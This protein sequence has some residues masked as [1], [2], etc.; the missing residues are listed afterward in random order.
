ML[1]PNAS[2]ARLFSRR[3]TLRVEVFLQ[4]NIVYSQTG[5][6]AMAYGKALK[7]GKEG[8]NSTR[9]SVMIFKYPVSRLPLLLQ[10][11]VEL[12]FTKKFLIGRVSRNYY[13][14]CM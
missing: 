9:K 10:Y 1:T 3:E 11:C 14:V 6:V 13:M 8:T 4:N 7:I 5:Q 2:H 12:A